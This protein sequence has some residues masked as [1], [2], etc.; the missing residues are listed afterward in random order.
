MLLRVSHRSLTGNM[1]PLGRSG[2]ET[3]DFSPYRSPKNLKLKP[4]RDITNNV[5]D[6][7]TGPVHSKGSVGAVNQNKKTAK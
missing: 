2:A 7:P 1:R 6:R 5:K 4:L 3:R